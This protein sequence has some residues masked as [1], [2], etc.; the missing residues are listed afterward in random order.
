MFLIVFFFNDTAT[1]EIYTLSLHDALPIAPPP[2]IATPGPSAK[3]IGVTDTG[4]ERPVAL[5]VPDARHHLHVIG[6]T[7]S[8]KSTLLGNMILAD[9]EAGRGI[10]LIDP[11]GDLV[12]D[13]LSRL[14][15][16]VADRVVIFDADSKSRPPC[17]NPL[18]GGETDLT[19]DNL[20]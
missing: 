15:R 13:M 12:T 5:R 7:G 20:V 16:A 1:T 4:H 19:V 10:V 14:P 2:G 3:P 11:K 9:A 17:L 18:D 8:G 6:A